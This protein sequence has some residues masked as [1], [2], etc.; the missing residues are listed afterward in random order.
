MARGATSG[1]IAIE[2]A[3]I[4]A[5]VRTDRR[6]FLCRNPPRFRSYC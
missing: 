4:K 5:K 1:A 2:A 6:Q 3:G